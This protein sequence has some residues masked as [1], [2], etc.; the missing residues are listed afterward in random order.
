MEE[1]QGYQKQQELWIQYQQKLMSEQTPPGVLL[2]QRLQYRE[3]KIREIIGSNLNNQEFIYDQKRGKGGTSGL[4]IENDNTE[5]VRIKRN[6]ITL[7]ER[8]DKSSESFEDISSTDISSNSPLSSCTTSCSQCNND[9]NG[10]CHM[11]PIFIPLAFAP[12]S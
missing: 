4:D 9:N 3:H 8:K 10:Q 6:S 5:T 12:P 11:V 1:L 7:E 2:E